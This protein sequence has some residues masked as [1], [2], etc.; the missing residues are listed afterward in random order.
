M[1]ALILSLVHFNTQFQVSFG[2]QDKAPD[3]SFKLM[4]WNVKLFDLYN[5]SGNAETRS[6]MFSVITNEQPAVLCLQEF[7]SQ[8]KGT[9]RNLDTLPKLLSLLHVHSAY[10]TTLRKTDHWGVATFSKYPIVNEGKIVFNVKSNNICIYTDLLVNKDTIRVYNMHL[11]SINFGYDDIHFVE[12]MLNEE[13][14]Q[15]E[16]ESS[17]NILRRMKRAY[18]RRA[19]QADAIAKH[20]STCKYPMIICG[21][22]N[23]TPISFTYNILTENMNDA[24]QESGSGFGKTFINPLPI[25]RIDYIL[26]SNVLKSWEFKTIETEGM[27]DHYPIVCKISL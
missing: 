20:M 2:E 8:D 12:T 3:N 18:T 7:Y 21:D 25:P 22:F 17:K 1:G 15:N 24:F 26:H 5:W 9:F 16:I 6:K 4:S 11:Q 13:E 23:D 14:A 10:T 27:S 19:G